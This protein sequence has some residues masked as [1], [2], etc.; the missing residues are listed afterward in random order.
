MSFHFLLYLINLETLYFDSRKSST[1]ENILNSYDF[2]SDQELMKQSKEC[3]EK[4]LK[5]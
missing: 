4:L 1:L 5:L 3:L 2:S